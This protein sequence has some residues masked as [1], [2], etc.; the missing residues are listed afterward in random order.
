MRPSSVEELTRASALELRDGFRAGAFS[1]V[2]VVEACAARIEEVEP[3]LKAFLTLTLDEALTEARRAEEAYVHGRARPLEGIPL[4]VK[5]LYDTAGV[6]TTYG[7]PIFAEHVPDAD[8]AAVRIAKEAGAIVLGKTSTQEFAWGISGYNVHFDSGRNPWDL[9]RV[10]GGSS[11]GSGAALAAFEAPL[12]LGTDTGGSIRA[13]AAFCG[14]V[15]FKPTFGSVSTE[16]VFPLASSLDTVGPLARTP[17]DAALLHSVLVQ[18]EVVPDPSTAHLRVATSPGL[19]SLETVPAVQEALDAALSV[20][21]GLGAELVEVDLPSSKESLAVFSVVQ[22]TEALLAHRSRGL[23]PDRRA[24]YGPDVLGRLESAEEL[25]R[26]QY[27]EATIQREWIRAA[28]ANAF[29]QADLIASPVAPLPPSRLGEEEVNHLGQTRLFRALMLHYT[30]PPNIVGV[31]SCSVRAGFD[32]L[33][34][35]IG[36]QL[37][38]RPGADELVLGA[39]QALFAATPELQ[40]RWPNL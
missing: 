25:T 14:L 4:A 36:V 40:A 7:S 38:G 11:G 9:D 17:G 24:Q 32:D 15:G 27:V 10:S 20:L 21:E 2:E 33:G 6:R 3:R 16:G 22:Q 23:W 34:I 26:E 18:R 28:W 13:P 19:M 31:P 8:A 39:A 1:P 5:D 35:P 37:A 30:T 12:A 29:R